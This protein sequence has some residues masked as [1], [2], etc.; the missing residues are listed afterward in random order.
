[1]GHRP[2]YMGSPVEKKAFF[3][4]LLFVCWFVF[5]TLCCYVRML[6]VSLQRRYTKFYVH[7]EILIK[8]TLHL[9][10][11]NYA[12]ITYYEETTFHTF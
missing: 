6:C 11:L 8:L 2:I 1:M 3:F 9:A 12:V 5:A 10:T 4:M 7:L